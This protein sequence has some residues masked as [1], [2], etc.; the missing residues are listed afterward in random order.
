[1]RKILT[2]AATSLVA[3]AV[4]PVALCG[5]A[6]ADTPWPSPTGSVSGAAQLDTPWPG[7]GTGTGAG[8]PAAADDTPWPVP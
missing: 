4:L 3:A 2:L 8:T 5:P 6:A 1:M 7:V